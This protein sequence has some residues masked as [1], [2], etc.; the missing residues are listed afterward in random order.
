MKNKYKCMAVP[1]IIIGDRVIFG[2]AENRDKLW[3]FRAIKRK[4][5][6]YAFPF[7]YWSEVIGF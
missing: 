6:I 2:F 5:A 3:N 1:T 4:A 7:K